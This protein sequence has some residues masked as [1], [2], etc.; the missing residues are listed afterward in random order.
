MRIPDHAALDGHEADDEWPQF[1]AWRT[2]AGWIWLGYFVAQAAL[3]AW[4]LR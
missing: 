2:V 3:G 1:D 4:I